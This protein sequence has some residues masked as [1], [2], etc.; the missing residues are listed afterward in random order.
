[1]TGRSL[2]VSTAVLTKFNDQC[3][4]LQPLLSLKIYNL[5]TVILWHNVGKFLKIQLW[6]VF[7]FCLNLWFALVSFLPWLH[8]GWTSVEAF[9]DNL[10]REQD[11]LK[12]ELLANDASTLLEHRSRQYRKMWHVCL[13]SVCFMRQFPIFKFYL[14]NS[15]NANVFAHGVTVASSAVLDAASRCYIA[16]SSAF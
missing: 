14:A 6:G 10:A 12:N 1:M 15:F 3:L 4:E 2:S 8:H 11:S 5:L 13:S 9:V 16:S 7:L